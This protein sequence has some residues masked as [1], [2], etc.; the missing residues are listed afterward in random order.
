MELIQNII[1]KINMHHIVIIRL[2]INETIADAFS[3]ETLVKNE[4]V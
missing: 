4:E 1:G 3:F 2:L